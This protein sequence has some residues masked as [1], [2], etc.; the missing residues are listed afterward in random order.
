MQQYKIISVIHL[1]KKLMCS[2]EKI[3]FNKY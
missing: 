1:I 2:I 3:V